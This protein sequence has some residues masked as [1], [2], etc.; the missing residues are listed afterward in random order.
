M[1]SGLELVCRFNALIEIPAFQSDTHTKATE[2]LFNH[3]MRRPLFLA[4][5]KRKS[6][7]RFYMKTT[8][9]SPRTQ[10]VLI[11]GIKMAA[12]WRKTK[13]NQVVITFVFK[14][15]HKFINNS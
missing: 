1:L 3:V 11:V 8:L 2:L 14:F 13:N 15:I 4:P 9:N 7:H 6:L 12:A 5:N 10:T